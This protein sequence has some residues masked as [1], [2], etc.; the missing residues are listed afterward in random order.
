MEKQVV[1][2]IP[3]EAEEL[4]CPD[5]ELREKVLQEFLML[6]E[7]Y[8]ERLRDLDHRHADMLT[9]VH[10]A[11]WWT[12]RI[13]R[14]HKGTSHVPK[15][16]SDRDSDPFLIWKPDFTLCECKALS[17]QAFET[18]KKGVLDRGPPRKPDSEDLKTQSS[19][20]MWFVHAH[21][22]NVRYSHAWVNMRSR[23]NI[24][25]RSA[26][27]LFVIGTAVAMLVNERSSNHEPNQEADC[28][29][30][31][32]SEHDS[33]LCEQAHYLLWVGCMTQAASSPLKQ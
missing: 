28:D 5:L 4:E 30:N 8:L 14:V 17:N 22:G 32:L 6:D 25:P 10:M 16:V 15:A 31:R 3:W 13:G 26:Q 1:E 21:F 7:K 18:W 27:I 19:F 24:L 33:L 20:W 29:P 11:Q 12:W 2:G 9:W 23:N